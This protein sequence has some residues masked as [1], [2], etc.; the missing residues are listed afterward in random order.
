MTTCHP[1]SLS[2]TDYLLIRGDPAYE[3]Y[4]ADL[5]NQDLHI[6]KG[7]HE[8]ADPIRWRSVEIHFVENPVPPFLRSLVNKLIGKDIRLSLD[9]HAFA[10][11][12][13]F[14]PPTR[15]KQHLPKVIEEILSIESS[16]WVEIVSPTQYAT[17]AAQYSPAHAS[18]CQLTPHATAHCPPAD[19]PARRCELHLQ[20]QISCRV[21]G[22]GGAIEQAIENGV[23]R[24]RE[25][26][27]P[28]APCS[29]LD[30]PR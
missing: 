13:A 12:S 7:A 22:M 19:P 1:L 24:V 10:T 8:G 27:S 15:L 28:A 9:E 4:K 23:R 21:F 3:A 5:V 14:D 18:S 11:R 2:G 16:E 17:V 6:T 29:T 20:H 25:S 30:P 26:N